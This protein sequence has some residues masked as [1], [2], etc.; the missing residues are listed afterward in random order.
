MVIIRDL[1]VS[2]IIS[3]NPTVDWILNEKYNTSIKLSKNLSD[4]WKGATFEE[5]S[6]KKS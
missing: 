1:L 5:L 6:I 2:G 4:L 3:P